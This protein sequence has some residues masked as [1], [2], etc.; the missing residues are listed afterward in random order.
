MSKEDI[1]A[2]AVQR[3]DALVRQ[4]HGAMEE[5]D[6]QRRLIIK[7]ANEALQQMAEAPV[8]TEDSDEED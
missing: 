3:M 8:P 5:F 1:F 2:E 7:E 4:M 6:F